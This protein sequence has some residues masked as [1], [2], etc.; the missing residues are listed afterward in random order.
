ML[1]LLLQMLE[2]EDDKR[3]FE[4]FFRKYEKLMFH[5][6]LKILRDETQAEDAVYEA[7]KDMAEDFAKVKEMPVNKRRSFAAVVTRNKAVDLLRGN[8]R[9]IPMDLEAAYDL[10]I[11]PESLPENERGL[12]AAMQRLSPYSRTVLLFRYE[13]G[14]SVNE[15]AERLK[16]KPAAVQRELTRAKARLKTLL[17]EEDHF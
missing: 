9:E 2:T 6:A 7:L 1:T 3:L 11:A 15:I 17:Y 16:R 4:Q 14:L 10:Q 8:S 12:A 13:Y 5:I